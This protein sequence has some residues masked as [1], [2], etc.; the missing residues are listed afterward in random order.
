[1][2]W[3]FAKAFAGP[4]ATAIA[5]G[6]AV[7]VTWKLGGNQIA[8][9][10]AQKEIALSQRDIAYDRL[11]WDLFAKRYEIYSVAGELI[12]HINSSPVDRAP[13]GPK[14]LAMARKLDEARFFFPD[15]EAAYFADIGRLVEEHEHALSR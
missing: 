3:K 10:S 9:A 11:K 2:L 12:D 14:I 5:S 4:I 8:I 1:M 15:R 7:W 6:A 13:G